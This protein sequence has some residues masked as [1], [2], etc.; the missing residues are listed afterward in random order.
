[1]S[2]EFRIIGAGEMAIWCGTSTIDFAGVFMSMH[3]LQAKAAT[4]FCRYRVEGA[5]QSR[6]TSPSWDCM[7]SRSKIT[8]FKTGSIRGS[9]EKHSRQRSRT[10]KPIRGCLLQ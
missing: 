7:P 10:R 3:P 8:F 4:D 5:G 6:V 1:M 2:G 9:P